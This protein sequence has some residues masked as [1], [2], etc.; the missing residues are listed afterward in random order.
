MAEILLGGNAC[1]EGHASSNVFKIIRHRMPI[2]S[3]LILLIALLLMGAS[4]DS[5]ADNS[6]LKLNPANISINGTLG[7]DSFQNRLSIIA[8]NSNISNLTF[9]PGNL[10]MISDRGEWMPSIWITSENVKVSPSDVK[11]ISKGGEQEFM[12]SVQGIPQSG[13]YSGK[14]YLSYDEQPGKPD[15]VTINL[16]A[17]KLNASGPIIREMENSFFGLMGI[18]SGP[19]DLEIMEENGRAPIEVIKSLTTGINASMGD[20]INPD[21]KSLRLKGADIFE[22]GKVEIKEGRIIIHTR[23]ETPD[24]EPG[25]YTGILTIKTARSLGPVLSIPVEMRIRSSSFLAALLIAFGL[26]ISMFCEWWKGKGKEITAI[27]HDADRIQRELRAMA[28]IECRKKIETLLKDI[29]ENIYDDDLKAAREK[30]DRADMELKRCAETKKK[31]DEKESAVG[32]LIKKMKEIERRASDILVNSGVENPDKSKVLEYLS[33]NEDG[34]LMLKRSIERGLYPGLEE[35]IWNEDYRKEKSLIEIFNDQN[36]MI[37]ELDQLLGKMEELVGYLANFK[38]DNKNMWIT[39]AKVNIEQFRD[40]V[41]RDHVKA[42][43]EQVDKRIGQLRDQ[44]VCKLVDMLGPLK[45]SAIGLCNSLSPEDPLR[46]QIE[47]LI[48]NL[49]EMEDSLA[50][51]PALES[52]NTLKTLEGIKKEL[53][54]IRGQIKIRESKSEKFSYK[55]IQA[56]VL[57]SKESLNAISAI[58]LVQERAAEEAKVKTPETSGATPSVSEREK[59]HPAD[60]TSLTWSP[61]NPLIGKPIRWTARAFEQKNDRT[62]YKFVLNHEERRDW[63]ADRTWEWTPNDNDKG[64]NILEVR[65]RYEMTEAFDGEPKYHKFELMTRDLGARNRFKMWWTPELQNWAG[66]SFLKTVAFLIVAYIGYV[67]LYANNPTFGAGNT[68]L[69]YLTL[70]LWGFGIQPGTEK[71]AELF[72]SLTA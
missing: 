19:Y 65:A 16:T 67:Q 23:F 4:S 38:G 63:N 60:V 13:R 52:D 25:K 49:N 64:G 57:Q 36:D 61:E 7:S 24:A 27:R 72:K 3:F 11:D 18:G 42:A 9:H 12:V 21:D 2:T 54:K 58:R 33:K 70:L 39:L 62:L 34:L 71:A 44:S 56:F 30:V 8:A 69:E 40:I 10:E 68:H 28:R 17:Y 53:E 47:P 15:K 50:L 66:K 51:Y 22:Q 14:L 48:D 29:V 26:L 41:S 45:E 31:L 37:S 35:K 55:E 32:D 5:L 43:I 20:L 59:P 46:E 1:I 6:P